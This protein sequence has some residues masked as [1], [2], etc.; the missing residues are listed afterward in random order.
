MAVVVSGADLPNGWGVIFNSAKKD[1]KVRHKLRST[2]RKE[3]KAKR[4]VQRYAL[5]GDYAGVH[6]SERE[7]ELLV[8][9]LSG[10]SIANSCKLMGLSLRT[11]EYYL[12]R[13][14]RKLKFYSTAKM[15]LELTNKNFLYSSLYLNM[16][17]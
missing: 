12:T 1:S 3:K 6:L 2:L 15:V 14:R 4:I 9:L 10:Y 8:Y 16:D 13:V 11:T 5:K 17:F 7:K